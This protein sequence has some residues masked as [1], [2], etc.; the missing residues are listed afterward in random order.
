MARFAGSRQPQIRNYEDPGLRSAGYSFGGS[1]AGNV[2][3]GS[4][5]GT[6]RDKS[7]NYTDNMITAASLRSQER[8]AVEDVHARAMA[9]GVQAA[10]GV[11]L[12]KIA[13]KN[14]KADSARRTKGAGIGAF[15]QIAATALP[16]VLSDEETKHTIDYLADATD[17]LRKLRP[18][19]FY[20]KDEYTANP[21]RMH[22]G[23][24]AQEYKE[25]MPD[26]TYYDESLEKYCIDTNELIALLVRAN[27]QLENRVMRLEAKNALLAV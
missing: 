8:N 7:P 9:L 6:I 23:F 26:A 5:F 12:G 21:E 10:K 13:V 11:E 16:L 15:A 14:A 22:Y 18:V 27:Q 19:T 2:N 20:Y 24:I 17:I 25:I 4:I 3:L 1:A